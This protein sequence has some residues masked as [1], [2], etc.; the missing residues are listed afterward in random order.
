MA[1]AAQPP[2]VSPGAVMVQVEQRTPLHHVPLT[3]VASFVDFFLYFH[4]TIPQLDTQIP[5][6]YRTTRKP[7]ARATTHTCTHA[8]SECCT[9][10]VY[11]EKAHRCRAEK[12]PALERVARRRHGACAAVGGARCGGRV[13]V[14]R[15]RRCGPGGLHASVAGLSSARAW[16]PARAQSSRTAG[17]SRLPEH[18]LAC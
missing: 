7:A 1:A 2:H 16:L 6:N 17:G 8:R 10:C 3:T 12:R 18:A 13:S 5:Y 4:P 9:Q 15:S 14:R 11:T